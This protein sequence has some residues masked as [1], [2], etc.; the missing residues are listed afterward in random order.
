MA[1]RPCAAEAEA[2]SIIPRMLEDAD[3]VV[4]SDYGKGTLT[5]EILDRRRRMETPGAD[6]VRLERRHLHRG[7]RWTGEDAEDP[8]FAVVPFHEMLNRW[9]V[10][11]RG[12]KAARGGA[13]R[14]EFLRFEPGDL[15]VHRDQGIARSKRSVR[16]IP[17]SDHAFRCV[18]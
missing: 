13:S 6:R 3:A 17:A 8:G 4:L 11:R 16:T 2:L 12:G 1:C 18:P 15:V 10:R 7:F 5:K 9:G 14:Q